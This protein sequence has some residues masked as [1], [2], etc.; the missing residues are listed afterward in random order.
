MKTNKTDGQQ[1]S[2]EKN[3]HKTGGKKSRTRKG[4]EKTKTWMAPPSAKK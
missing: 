3:E 4:E 2:L 1:E